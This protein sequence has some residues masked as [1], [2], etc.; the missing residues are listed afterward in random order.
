[1]KAAEAVLSL[2][3]GQRRRCGVRLSRAQVVKYTSEACATG[4]GRFQFGEITHQ[5]AG[6]LTPLFSLESCDAK[7]FPDA[8]RELSR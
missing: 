8:A 3:V 4:A 1:M 6:R 2:G 5:I 7:I